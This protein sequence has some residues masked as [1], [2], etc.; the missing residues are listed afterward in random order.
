MNDVVDAFLHLLHDTEKCIRQSLDYY[1]SDALALT[2]F[3]HD[4][5]KKRINPI[6][7]MA[8]QPR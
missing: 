5:R 7:I 2:D 8:E 3:L 4:F 6:K 1:G